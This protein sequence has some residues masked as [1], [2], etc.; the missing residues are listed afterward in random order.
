MFLRELETMEQVQLFLKWAQAYI[1]VY[2]DPTKQLTN[3]LSTTDLDDSTTLP[4]NVEKMKKTFRT[5]WCAMDFDSS[6]QKAVFCNDNEESGS[7]ALTSSWMSVA[8]F[9]A[10]GKSLVMLVNEFVL[11]TQVVVQNCRAN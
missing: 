2:N 10:V 8:F 4:M 5:H 9:V 1:L 6:F 3:L 7:G 11:S